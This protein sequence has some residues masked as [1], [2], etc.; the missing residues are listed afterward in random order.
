M[1]QPLQ[2]I[3]TTGGPFSEVSEATLE[4]RRLI[5]F[6]ADTAH[7]QTTVHRLRVC[8]IELSEWWRPP[9]QSSFPRKADILGPTASLKIGHRASHASSCCLQLQ[10]YRGQDRSN[11]VSSLSV[12]AT[13][14]VSQYPTL[15]SESLFQKK[16]KGKL[17][18]TQTSYHSV[19]LFFFLN[20]VKIVQ[21]YQDKGRKST[22]FQTQGTV[23]LSL[24]HFSNIP[25]C[26]C[27][28]TGKQPHLLVLIYKVEELPEDGTWQKVGPWGKALVLG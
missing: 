4:L 1:C 16:G 23:Q 2:H 3:L 7:R 20:R 9:P 18:T 15:G 25:E 17:L 11:V 26:H 21:N 24:T 28:L 22:G 14:W 10:Q 8:F 13:H 6:H 27:A 5:S 19:V 12:W